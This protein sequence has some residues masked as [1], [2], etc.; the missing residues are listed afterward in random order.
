M[1]SN[2]AAGNNAQVKSQ[3]YSAF[4]GGLN[5]RDH[6]TKIADNEL[7]VADNIRLDEGGVVRGRGAWLKYSTTAVGTAGN[8]IGIVQGEWIIAGVLTRRTVATDGVKVFYGTGAAW[9]DITGAVVNTAT[10]SSL[11]SFLSFNNVLIGY[12]GTSIPWTWDGNAGSIVVLA[13][14]PPVATIG[15]VWQNRVFFAGVLTARTRL[16]YSAIGDQLTWGASAY[17]DIPSPYDGDEITGLAVLY[18]NLIVFK[19]K[20][21]YIVQG[22]SPEN[23]VISKTNSAV[24]CVSPSSVIGV[25]MTRL[26][27]NS[28]QSPRVTLYAP[29]Y[30]A[31]SSPMIKTFSSLKSSS[32]SAALSASRIVI[33]AIFSSEQ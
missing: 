31:T 27:P 29:S 14:S 12:G 10:T 7:T 5:I 1:A 23:W 24:G 25:S 19:R 11:I 28:F 22:D 4:E 33:S 8:L 16:Y 18:G 3:E 15:I 32:R 9:T 13:G 2:R 20:S 17:V 6:W 30:S 21:I 26:S